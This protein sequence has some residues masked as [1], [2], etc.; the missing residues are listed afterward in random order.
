M[1]I[2]AHESINWLGGSADLSWSWLISAGITGVCDQP[3][4]HLVAD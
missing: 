2:F 4:G 1:C 3:A